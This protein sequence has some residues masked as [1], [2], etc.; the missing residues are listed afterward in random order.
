MSLVDP[1][2]GEISAYH[3]E[4]PSLAEYRQ[5]DVKV[6][7]AEHDG[8]LARWEFGQR[9]VEERLANGGK[10]LPHGRLDEVA[11][12]IGKSRSEIKYRVQFADRYRTLEEV[13]TAVATY[14][15]WTE[16]RESFPPD[17]GAHVA[18]NS[19]DNEWY[20]PPEFIKAA[21][22]VM[23][24]IDLD[25][26]SSSTA[27]EQV[28]AA[29]FYD[30]TMNGLEQIWRGRVWMNP[31]Y[32]Q[33]LCGEFCERLASS[34]RDGAVT[35]AIVLVN[36]ATETAWFSHLAGEASAMCFPLGR[37]KFW[38]P[39]KVSAP[40]QGQAVVYMGDEVDLFRAEFAPFGFTVAL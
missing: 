19:G 24:G 6:D 5:L 23:G 35:A 40:L 29:T 34:Y 8:I 28:G 38:H 4:D 11:D 12:A 17:K 16:V 37:V 10:Q 33:P 18:A 7:A 22:A 2:T 25:P 1:V 13:A 20:T 30:A 15:S 26:A 27:N 32:A 3:A 14:A 9:L 39:D 21:V 36:N 31:P